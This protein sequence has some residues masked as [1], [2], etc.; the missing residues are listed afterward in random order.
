MTK[1]ELVSKIVELL[2][3]DVDLSFLLALEK[4]QLETLLACIRERVDY[5]R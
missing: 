4:A 5:M 1:E 3:T 2:R